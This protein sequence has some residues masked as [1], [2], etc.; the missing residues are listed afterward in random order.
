MENRKIPM[1]RS[2]T[3]NPFLDHDRIGH[4]GLESFL[5]IEPLERRSRPVNWRVRRHAHTSLSQI[6]L[7]F[8]GG[9]VI[10]L[11]EKTE[12]FVGPG[13]I[14]VPAGHFH[15]LSYAPCTSGYVLTLGHGHL[16]SFGEQCPDMMALLTH[17]TMMKANLGDYERILGITRHQPT[18]TDCAS[19]LI[20]S[21]ISQ[22]FL[23][24]T[25][26]LLRST[27][28]P[29]PTGRDVQLVEA[30]HSLIENDLTSRTPLTD[31]L[32]ILN[33]S[34]RTLRRACLRMALPSPHEIIQMRLSSEAQRLLLFSGLSAVEISERLG[35]TD[36]AYFS[37]WFR[38]RHGLTIRAFREEREMK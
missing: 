2:D 30:F 28:N 26:R 4:V 6:F 11:D 21:A 33:T 37:R 1:S 29:S 31:Y 36:P 3:P 23:T 32:K 16:R 20:N 19:A 18:V 7:L 38:H 9:G 25:C 12:N 14:W 24:L 8:T 27:Q 13:F 5:H 22:L 35:F 34:E 10:E 15:S 17:P